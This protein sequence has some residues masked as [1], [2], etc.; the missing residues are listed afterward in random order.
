MID[1]IGTGT[2]SGVW[3]ALNIINYDLFA[4]K[5]Q[6][7]DDCDDGEKEATLLSKVPSNSINL[8]KLV[9]YFRVR[10]PLDDKN[11]NICMVMD[12]CIG[13]TYQLISRGGYK[14]GFNIKICNKIIKDVLNGLHQL[15]KM[16][17]IHTDIKPENVLIKGLNPIF[18]E[19]KNLINKSNLKNDIDN[20]IIKLKIIHKLNMDANKKSTSYK[21]RLNKF[22]TDKTN[23]LK[24]VSKTLIKEFKLICN[25]FCDDKY[26][27]DDD[28]IYTP[29]YYYKR[30]N[31]KHNYDLENSTYILSDF[32]TIKNINKTHNSLIQTRYYRA[33]E[34]ILECNWNEFVDIWSIGCLYYE[35]ICGDILFNPEKDDRYN[36][37]MHH[38]LWISQIMTI[39]VEQYKSGQKY[40]EFFNKKKL[41]VKE[42][43]VKYDLTDVISEQKELNKSDLLFVK[44]FILMTLDN[45][46]N[47][48]SITDLLAFID[49][50]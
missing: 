27:D 6:H 28:E 9:E 37:D 25:N 39:D 1:K 40:D 22:R 2:F 30:F 5:I 36:T 45:C 35:L 47:R 44:R 7:C 33:P 19:F 18:Q 11:I 8:P 29:N 17:Y 3:L 14:N 34:V 15:N 38:L 4:I 10:N 48:A 23:F 16:G 49:S 26:K 31:F 50:Y 46:K 21:N 32:G 20:E 43:I 42:K 12:L 13:S 41:K 24:L